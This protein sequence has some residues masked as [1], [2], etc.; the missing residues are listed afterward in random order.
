MMG[1]T[2]P[3]RPMEPDLVHYPADAKRYARLE[4]GESDPAWLMAEARTIENG[5]ERRWGSM[6]RAIIGKVAS[7]LF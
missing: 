6:F 3:S 5:S 1:A 2:F 7:F 4:W